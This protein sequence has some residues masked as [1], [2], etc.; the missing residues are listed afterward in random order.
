MISDRSVSDELSAIQVS[1]LTV[2]PW[3][4]VPLCP[5][6]SSRTSTGEPESIVVAL[7]T[8]MARKPPS[9][10]TRVLVE[11]GRAR[12]GAGLRLSSS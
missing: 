1:T 5:S 8:M 3:S 6:D 2:L 12:F 9:N 11:A 10:R 4:V 7:H